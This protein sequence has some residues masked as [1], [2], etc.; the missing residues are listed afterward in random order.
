MQTAKMKMD[1]VEFFLSNCY[2]F[3]LTTP[4]HQLDKYQNPRHRRNVTR[5][6]FFVYYY[7]FHYLWPANFLWLENFFMDKLFFMAK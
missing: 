3:L 6:H 2:G 7:F 4:G 1:F 5:Y